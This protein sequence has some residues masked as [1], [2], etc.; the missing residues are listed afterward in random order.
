MKKH[1]KSEKRKLDV[2][3]MQIPNQ[4]STLQYSN[5]LLQ[6]FP[7]IELLGNALP[8]TVLSPRSLSSL[9]FR[10]VS[11]SKNP[12]TQARPPAVGQYPPGAIPP[13]V[14]KWVF[15]R[16]AIVSKSWPPL[17]RLVFHRDICCSSCAASIP[18]SHGG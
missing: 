8:S 17:S 16:L 11:S 12:P 3:L 6:W 7:K 14:L 13:C 4:L 1:E 2:F 18:P 15:T 10:D 5:A 9:R